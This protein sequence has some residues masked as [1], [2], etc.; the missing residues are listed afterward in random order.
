MAAAAIAIDQPGHPTQ[1][2]GEDDQSRD[3]LQLGLIRLRNANDA[4]VRSWLWEFV[5]VPEG[6]AATLSNPLSAQPEF[7]A[8]LVG[9]YF[10]KLTVNGGGLGHVSRRVA[11]V[12]DAEG[13][14]V[15]AAGEEDEANYDTG[16][17]VLNRKGWWP[18]IKRFFDAIDGIP[19]PPT[20]LVPG[21]V[22]DN[23][24]ALQDAIDN[25]IAAGP[26]ATVILPPGEYATGNLVIE[27]AE[28]FALVGNGTRL[29][30]VGSSV[31]GRVGIQLRGTLDN[32]KIQGLH[33][34]GDGVEANR[35]AGIYMDSG[36]TLRAVSYIENIVENTTLGLSLN[37]ESGGSIRDCQVVR[38]HVRNVV[39]ISSGFGYGIHVADGTGLPTRTLIADNVID[40]AQRHSIYLALGHGFACRNNRIDRHRDG[41]TD[42]AER[43]AIVVARGGDHEIS[44]NVLTRLNNCGIFL[45]AGDVADG[46]TLRNVVVQGNVFVAPVV[47]GFM[48]PLLEVGESIATPTDTI[49][50]ISIIG[51][52]FDAD[53]WSQTAI[54]LNWGKGVKVVGNTINLRNVVSTTYAIQLQARGES[55]GSTTF[56]DRW[57]IAANDVRVTGAGGGAAFRLNPPFNDDSGVAVDFIANTIDAPAVFSTSAAIDNPNIFVAGQPTTG[58]SFVAGF[59]LLGRPVKASTLDVS[60]VSTLV[61]DLNLHTPN[62]ALHLGDGST[63][64]NVWIEPRKAD[65]NALTFM[66]WRVGTAGSGLR[67]LWQFGTDEDLNLQR[68]DASGVLVD[69]PLILDWATGLTTLTQA[70]IPIIVGSVSMLTVGALLIFGDGSTA[71][72][73]GWEVRKA[74]ANNITFATLRNGTAA[75]GLRHLWQFDSSENVNFQAADDSGNLHA[76]IPVS[77]QRSATNG[78]TALSVDRLTRDRSTAL[79]ASDVALSAGWGSTAAVTAISGNY[80]RG[81]MTITP[82]GAGIA[83]NPTVTVT[84]PRGTWAA[85]GI[86]ISTRNGGTDGVFLRPGVDWTTTDNATTFVFTMVGTPVSGDTV[87]IRWDRSG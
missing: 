41:T 85:A 67:W 12:R 24:A 29:I 72:N 17:G 83:A 10:V 4:G 59:S 39:G 49:D 61:G 11:I 2:D 15:P 43:A 21:G 23:T 69:T 5:D 14:R 82:G 42:G 77:I 3:D 48:I 26:G 46:R 22:V 84:D 71:G 9:T 30:I 47:S 64:G 70:T 37:A 27:D 40:Q 32:V 75:A 13:M 86:T 87:I 79:Q 19:V 20:G 81:Q 65:A 53:G 18:E 33:I 60:G 28:G 62:Q 25:A 78:R 6:S 66:Q 45:D 52:T 74:D 36:Q 57:T 8:D 16:G 68:Y 44:G 35:H 1:V 34:V 50:S 76:I 58:L 80:S 55:A 54:R 73:V 63:A 31:A 7:T 38:N 51:N 56:S